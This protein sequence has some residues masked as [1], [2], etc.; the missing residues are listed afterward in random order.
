MVNLDLLQL[1]RVSFGIR[2]PFTRRSF[3]RRKDAVDV[4]IFDDI[5]PGASS[6]GDLLFLSG[7]GKLVGGR[8]TFCLALLQKLVDVNAYAAEMVS[9]RENRREEVN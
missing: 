3:G 5:F 2:F 7:W 6:F 9:F 1:R 4:F 8:I